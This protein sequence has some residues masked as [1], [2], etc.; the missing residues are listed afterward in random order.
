MTAA[1]NAT[2]EPSVRRR[3]DHAGGNTYV[4]GNVTADNQADFQIQLSG[5]HTLATDDF[6]L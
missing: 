5:L 4:V 3:A 6:W 2:A 1:H